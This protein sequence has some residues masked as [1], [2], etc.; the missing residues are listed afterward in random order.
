M[1]IE[2]RKLLVLLLTVTLL[3]GCLGGLAPGQNSGPPELHVYN[4]VNESVEVSVTVKSLPSNEN[5][6]TG[7][8]T[9]INTTLKLEANESRV[10]QEEPF[11]YEGDIIF[12]ARTHRG[13]STSRIFQDQQQTDE[14][15]IEIWIFEAKIEIGTV[16]A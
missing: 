3:A 16:V 15:G 4:Q 2:P 13:H 8:V 14:T 12:S 7:N 1:S 6:L 9:L 5:E 10:L 11:E